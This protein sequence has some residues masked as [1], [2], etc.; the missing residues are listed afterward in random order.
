[1]DEGSRAEALSWLDRARDD[2]GAAKKLLSGDDPYPAT[3]AYHCQQ[4]AEKAL[5]AVLSTTAQPIPK[6][7]DLRVL[8]ALSANVE[9]VL[10]RFTDA[11]EFLTPFAT[12]FRYP[13]AM[14][15]PTQTDVAEAIRLADEILTTVESRIMS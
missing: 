4:C 14:P 13:S 15:D 5:K 11:A 12:E 1:M 2:L 3:A 7:H 10:T 8:L 9:S 6:T